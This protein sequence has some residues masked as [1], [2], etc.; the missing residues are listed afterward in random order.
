MFGGRPAHAGG[1]TSARP[2]EPGI[3]N[4]APVTLDGAEQLTSLAIT[5]SRWS[6]RRIRRGLEVLLTVSDLT[7]GSS[8]IATSNMAMAA[9]VV[10]PADGA[11][12]TG[13]V[14][15]ATAG[16]LAA[17]GEKIVTA[18]VGE[19]EGSYLVSPGILDE[20]TVPAD[21]D[22]WHLFRQRDIAVVS[23]P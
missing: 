13:V 6:T 21:A 14:A 9:P 20:L 11:S 18:D 1:S 5:R 19:G 15:H 12:M 7:N 3:S 16:N 22:G 4:F 23:G 2:V 10:A 17:T 8:T